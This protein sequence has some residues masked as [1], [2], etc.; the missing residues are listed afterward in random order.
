[1]AGYTTLSR[2]IIEDTDLSDLLANAYAKAVAIAWDNAALFGTGTAPQ[3][4]GIAN[5]TAITDKT[6]LGT[7]GVAFTYDHVIDAVGA[8]RG[9]NEVCNAALLAP[10]SMQSLGKLKETSTGAYLAP[11]A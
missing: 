6:A 10:R 7:N 3:P 1:L 2:E 5:N 11:P 4:L 8:V 9:R